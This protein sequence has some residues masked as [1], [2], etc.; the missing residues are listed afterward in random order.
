MTDN[1]W[2]RKLGMTNAPAPVPFQPSTELYPVY[3]A[4]PVAQ[5]AVPSQQMAVPQGQIPQQEY[6]PSVRM[7]QGDICPGCGGDKYFRAQPS[8]MP[9]CGD[10]GYNTRFEQQ[11]YGAPTLKADPKDVAP[12]KQT[13][14]GQTMQQSLAILQAGGGEHL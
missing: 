10:C 6:T 13:G 14:G 4:P 5:G 8:A 12:A 1:F 7:K 11:A 9:I 3:T 2:A